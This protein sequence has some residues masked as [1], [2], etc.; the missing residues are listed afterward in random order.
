MVLR[1]SRWVVFF[2][3]FASKLVCGADQSLYSVNT[4]CQAFGRVPHALK[5]LTP[6]PERLAYPLKWS[7]LKHKCPRTCAMT[8][9]SS[10]SMPLRDGGPW[11]INRTT[12]A[13]GWR[14][15]RHRAPLN[16]TYLLF[17]IWASLD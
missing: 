14:W 2:N 17:L 10:G 13:S 15:E 1:L 4:L 3:R 12:A 5:V 8:T 7:K 9:L 16:T 11:H 6:C